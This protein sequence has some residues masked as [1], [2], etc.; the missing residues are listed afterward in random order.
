MVPVFWPTL[1]MH[2]QLYHYTEIVRLAHNLLHMAC[3]SRTEQFT[4]CYL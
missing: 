2:L 3:R 4:F 1:Y